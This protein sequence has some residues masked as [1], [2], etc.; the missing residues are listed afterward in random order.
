MI[1]ST[2][3]LI[4]ILKGLVTPSRTVPTN[5][6][7]LTAQIDTKTPIINAANVLG[8]SVSANASNIITPSITLPST[9]ILV[10][11][12]KGT[13]TPSRTVPPTG[14]SISVNAATTINPKLSLC[15]DGVNLNQSVGVVTPDQNSNQTSSIG[16]NVSVDTIQTIVQSLVG[17]ISSLA[18]RIAWEFNEIKK[19]SILPPSILSFPTSSTAVLDFS[20]PV[21]HYGLYTTNKNITLGF[22]NAKVGHRVL[23]R[24]LST[25]PPGASN[26][27]NISWPTS[28]HTSYWINGALSQTKVYFAEI[29]C[30]DD[31]PGSEW[32]WFGQAGLEL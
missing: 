7:T 21:T 12:L 14:P 31:T 5:G 30:V 32:F 4:N 19:S 25:N 16:I 22:T 13:V 8:G 17:N 24:L 3:V 26:N 9:G 29:I 20:S 6:T 27:Y 2:G 10:N 18:I 28:F 15:G 1:N 11:T 23:I